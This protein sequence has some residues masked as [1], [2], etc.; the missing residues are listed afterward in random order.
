MNKEQVYDEKIV[1]LMQQIIEVCQEHNIGMIADF[2]IPD[3]E[4]SDL[5]GWGCT[6]VLP[7]EN[8]QVSRRH[9]L[10]RQALMGE[11]LAFAVTIGK[12]G[13]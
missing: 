8:D 6:S 5:W 9:S 7:S 11:G 3:D 1:P 12:E 4:D 2:E 10:A 13:A